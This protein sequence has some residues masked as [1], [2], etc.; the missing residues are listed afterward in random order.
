MFIA[1]D[2]SGQIDGMLVSG[3]VVA[4]GDI[5]EDALGGIIDGML[6]SGIVVAGGYRLYHRW[7]VSQW[8]SRW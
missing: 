2:G 5:V 1:S 6:V 3:I 4:G 8:H 7:H